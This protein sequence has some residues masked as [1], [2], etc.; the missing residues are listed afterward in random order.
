MPAPLILI[1][2]DQLGCAAPYALAGKGN[3]EN[4]VQYQGRRSDAATVPVSALQT[5]HP[6]TK[7]G[8]AIV[9]PRLRGGK[10]GCLRCFTVLCGALQVAGHSPAG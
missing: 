5:T 1:R 6:S 10:S 7:R 4:Q 2:A 3:T 8:K 9:R